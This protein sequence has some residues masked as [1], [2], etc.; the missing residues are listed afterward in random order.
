MDVAL[1]QVKQ[2]QFITRAVDNKKSRSG[3]EEPSINAVSTSEIEELVRL[4]VENLGKNPSNEAPNYSKKARQGASYK[5]LQPFHC[6]FCRNEGH[7][8]KDFQKWKQFLA[9]KE[10]ESGDLNTK[11]LYGKAT[12][13]GPKK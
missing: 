6:Y 9:E 1:D 3:R 2:Y 4:A 11:G 5:K 8:K 7:I 13:P 12:R 10:K